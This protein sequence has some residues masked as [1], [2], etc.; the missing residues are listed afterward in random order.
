MKLIL[1]IEYRAS[2]CTF[3]SLIQ[4]LK[5]HGITAKIFKT[6]RNIFS[7][8]GPPN[9]PD[10]HFSISFIKRIVSTLTNMP[11][12]TFELQARSQEVAENR[13]IA[14]YLS[15]KYT[16]KSLREIGCEFGNKTPATIVHACKAIQNLIQTD[17]TFRNKLDRIEMNLVSANNS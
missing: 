1:E 5:K 17:K 16:R 12:E 11:L 3:I 2:E 10:P 4:L 15:R 8:S 6:E 9:A 7:K 14:M 13:Q